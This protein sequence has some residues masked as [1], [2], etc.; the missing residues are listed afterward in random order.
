MSFSHYD[1]HGARTSHQSYHT[2]F[3]IPEGHVSDKW[4]Y[5]TAEFHQNKLCYY[6]KWSERD[7][8][9]VQISF[10]YLT[11]VAEAIRDAVRALP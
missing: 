5:C 2:H 6:E 3:V 11:K 8:I 7:I 4:I 1:E 9:F 10:Q